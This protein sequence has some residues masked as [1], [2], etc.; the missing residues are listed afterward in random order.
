MQSCITLFLLCNVGAASKWKQSSWLQISMSV[1]DSY[2]SVTEL[3][4]ECKHN[5]QCLNTPFVSKMRTIVNF[6][7]TDS[8]VSSKITLQIFSNTTQLHSHMK[9]I[10]FFLNCWIVKRIWIRVYCRSAKVTKWFHAVCNRY[11]SFEF[12]LKQFLCEA[13]LGVIYLLYLFWTH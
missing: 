9:S 7:D 2:I 3:S 12:L 6:V 8:K 5:S 13:T 11:I 1:N 10:I 4:L